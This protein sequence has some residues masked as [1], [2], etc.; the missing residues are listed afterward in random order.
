MPLLAFFSALL[1]AETFVEFLLA[2]WIP[3]DV[4]VDAVAEVRELTGE[5]AMAP[6]NGRVEPE[7]PLRV[8][9]RIANLEGEVPGVRA[10][11]IELLQCRV[12]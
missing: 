2:D 5:P 7:C 11:E 12:S 1:M 3:E 10:K 6:A 9:I 8:E 4:V